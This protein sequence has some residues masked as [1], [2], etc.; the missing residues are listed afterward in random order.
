M[1]TVDRLSVLPHNL[2][3]FCTAGA[4]YALLTATNRAALL[5]THSIYS[6]FVLARLLI[7]Q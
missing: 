4:D 2:C 3:K 5:L 7:K 1:Q 6:F